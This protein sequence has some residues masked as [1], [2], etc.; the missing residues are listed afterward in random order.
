VEPPASP[1]PTE[2]PADSTAAIGVANL[3][4][5]LSLEDLVTTAHA[6]PPPPVQP[7]PAPGPIGTSLGPILD[8]LEQSQVSGG[9]A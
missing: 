8:P 3:A 2:P 4:T 7:T 5:T 6:Y 1:P 9:L